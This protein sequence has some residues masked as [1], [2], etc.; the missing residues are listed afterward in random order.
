MSATAIAGSAEPAVRVAQADPAPSCP[1]SRIQELDG[2]RGFSVVMLFMCHYWT[3]LYLQNAAHPA[4]SWWARFFFTFNARGIDCFFVLSGFLIGGILLGTRTSPRYFRTFY[5]RR[6]YR[7][8]PLY[9]VWLGLYILI[10]VVLGL[11]RSWTP[12]FKALAPLPSYL[13]FLQNWWH[14]RTLLCWPHPAWFFIGPM[15]SLAVEEQFYLVAPALIKFCSRR[16]LIY[17]LIFII[18][19]APIFRYALVKLSTAGYL[20][21]FGWTPAR[22]DEL[23]WG[24][25]AAALY[26][27]LKWRDWITRHL[28]QIY[29]TIT[30]SF[31]FLLGLHL[32][33][34][35][36][37]ILEDYY[38]A[39]TA[40][41][42]DTVYSLLFSCVVLVL[43]NDPR[44][45]TARWF[46]N[47]W[48]SRLASFSY[49]A[50]LV[51]LGVLFVCFRLLVHKPP[52]IETWADFGVT[53]IA[54]PIAILLALGSWRFFEEPILR[55]ARRTFKY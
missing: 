4:L 16:G 15:W 23:A 49:G 48:L 11:S 29:G 53:L 34:T 30:L 44:S 46:R 37:H 1:P 42:G 5:L 39:P 32:S 38:T 18:G 26:Y 28:Q 2:L 6:F 35:N 52:M 31:L 14:V 24:L 22:L 8:M 41:I 33:Q 45:L 3:G 19:A 21:A 47:R 13:V 25:L 55:Y 10:F 12:G 43:V 20:E 51:Q 9:Y 54:F 17:C 7:L 36:Y 50:Y 40:V 27:D